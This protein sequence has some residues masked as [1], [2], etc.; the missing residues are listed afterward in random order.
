MIRPIETLLIANRGEIAGRIQR[1]CRAMGI[2]TVA[3]YSDADRALPF[4]R[5]ADLAL[6]LGTGPAGESYLAMEAVL[7][8]AL[9]NGVDAIHP[10]YGF[11]SENPA[12]S[13][14]CEERGLI[15]VGPP[16]E[17]I[18]V[19]G[20][21]AEAKRRVAEAGVP[22]LPG[23]SGEAAGN[24][25][26]EATLKKEAERIGY[27]VLLKA[28]AGG[29]GRGIRQ[30]NTPADLT[31]AL[32]SARREALAAF[33]DER[34]MLEK[35]LPEPR[36][37]E[38]QVLG[39][40]HGT[41]LHLFERECSVQRRHQKVVEETPSPALN[42]TLRTAMAEAA[43]RA[44]KSV[45]YVGAGTVE[46]LLNPEGAFH[47]L[48]MNT[49]LQVEHPVTEAVLGLDLVRLQIEVAEGRPLALR[50][51][52]LQPR[53]HAIE[54]RLNAEDPAQDF[55]PGT[56][57]LWALGFPTGEGLRVDAGFEAGNILSPYYDSLVAKLIAWGPDRVESLRRMGRML[58]ETRLAGPATNLDYLGAI[59]DHPAFRAGETTT[60]FLERHEAALQ[61]P[62]VSPGLRA[63]QLL[64][65]AAVTAW[66]TR[67]RL[68]SAQTGPSFTL[69]AGLHHGGLAGR[70]RR[71]ITLPSG[72]WN[73][74]CTAWTEPEGSLRV[75]AQWDALS[76][77]EGP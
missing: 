53:G 37:V 76:G 75:A 5:E 67:E 23:W 38:F 66:E 45:G 70:Q 22:V 21:K 8:A 61:A 49:R 72:V 28:L 64:A 77:T 58:A 47:F 13:A 2:R 30:V 69:G 63:E 35:Y 11:L 26:S 34:M 12:F 68:R 36:H 7:A 56:G 39:D 15:F 18:R 51:E 55:L 3:V 54:C 1:T 31:P 41:V 52:D 42:P 27:P 65:L 4:V 14:A 73:T 33:G 17:V 20:D 74:A 48:E 46:F 16:A 6:R 29:G 71:T 60:R 9:G 57:R 59:V 10:G 62:A 32:A 19:M 44:A 25:A 50:Q 40:I 43:V 24:K